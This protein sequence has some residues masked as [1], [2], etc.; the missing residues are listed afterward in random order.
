MSASDIPPLHE[1]Q[2]LESLDIIAREYDG[3]I[4]PR[5]NGQFFQDNT[6]HISNGIDKPIALDFC[7]YRFY[8]NTKLGDNINYGHL[9][10]LKIR[11][12]H[13]LNSESKNTA[14]PYSSKTIKRNL[15]HARAFLIP[16][17]KKHGVLEVN[18]QL[19]SPSH[20]TLS[21]FDTFIDQIIESKSAKN[22]KIG[23]LDACFKYL[24]EDLAVPSQF[25]SPLTL[26]RT[27]SAVYFTDS[28]ANDEKGYEPIPDNDLFWIG[29]SALEFIHN[30]A[31]DIIKLHDIAVAVWKTVPPD[32]IQSRYNNSINKKYCKQNYYI[33]ELW[34]MPEL[35]RRMYNC[36]VK[37]PVFTDEHKKYWD[38]ECISLPPEDSSTNEIVQSGFTTSY[39]FY[40]F[41]LLFGALNTIIFAPTGMRIGEVRLLDKTRI[42]DGPNED[43][44][45]SY[46]NGI[47]KIKPSGSFI[48]PNEIPIPVET[49]K[50]MKFLD[51]LTAP[52][53]LSN[54][55]LI[56]IPTLNVLSAKSCK[57]DKFGTIIDLNH[58]II[59][60]DFISTAIALFCNLIRSATIP[61]THRFR[62][63]IAEFM[64]RK[65][66]LAPI[67]ICQLFGHRD[68]RM[69]MKY[70]RKNKLIRREM[71]KY[72]AERFRDGAVALAV[73]LSNGAA[74]GR[75]VERIHN[76]VIARD[77]FKG[78]T[79][80]EMGLMLADYLMSR[81]NHG[82]LIILHTPLSLCCRLSTAKDRPPCMANIADQFDSG[83][84][85]PSNCTGVKC[86]WSVVTFE[87]AENL[88][89][90]LLFY[91]NTLNSLDKSRIRN[92]L[93]ISHASDMIE[94]YDPI[95]NCIKQIPSDVLL[96]QVGNLK[97]KMLDCAK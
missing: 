12:F 66:H 17:F 70:L 21:M 90:S 59:R 68:I 44:I 60:H 40:L 4:V 96:K 27:S 49:W 65:T 34:R 73:A 2:Y 86:D 3:L 5:T 46:I 75:M 36:G 22:S 81:I 89:V 67:L 88:N 62:K 64:L 54:S 78:L 84:P 85:D 55:S 8:D 92:G 47:V 74:G 24:S 32:D 13:L 26:F 39:L 83:L 91:K 16:L 42:S 25:R 61:T 41:K 52:L 14:Q 80:S 82:D 95:L 23:I 37:L 69:T 48:D 35:L 94:T 87:R 20:L 1:N 31:E 11:T 29:K 76:S 63:S 51:R 77:E 50:A 9:L 30:Y 72:N 33:N 58:R 56:C 45:Y 10:F 7:R 6:W 28:L 19:R 93:M 71:R 43:G 18:K 38:I 79:Q 53:R 15:S 57:A 97:N